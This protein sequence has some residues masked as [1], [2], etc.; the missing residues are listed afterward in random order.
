MDH[1]FELPLAPRWFREVLILGAVSWIFYY[2]LLSDPP[3][4]PEP[5]FVPTDVA[6]HLFAYFVLGLLIA[7]GL[8]DVNLDRRQKLVLLIIVTGGYGL[9]IELLQGLIPL[10]MFSLL[11]MAANV[12]GAV[13]SGIWYLVED[14]FEF[15]PH[16]P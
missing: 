7:Y 16:L 6:L 1:Q 15:Y 2:S 10:R 13:M 5:G 14:R 4:V 9:I 3:G 8:V 12:I 11:D